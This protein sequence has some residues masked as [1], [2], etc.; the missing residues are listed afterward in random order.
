M[1]VDMYQHPTTTANLKKL[2]S[3][4]NMII[5][6]P[7]GEL[8]SGLQGEGR[9]AEPEDILKVLRELFK[10]KDDL[11]GFSILVTAGPTQERIDQVRFISN[12]S[13]GKMGFA[14]ANALADRGADVNLISGPSSQKIT[15]SRVHEIP[16]ITAIEMYEKCTQ[17]YDQCDVAIFSAAVADFRPAEANEGKIKKSNVDLTLRLKKNPDIAYELGK[18]KK[19]NQINIG[20]A[21]ETDNEIANA[22]LKLNEK[23]FDFIVLNSLKDPGAGF[24]SEKNKITIIDR[25]GKK[26]KFPLKPKAL[27]A[28]DIVDFLVKRLNVS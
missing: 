20:F 4:G 14:L 13:S 1:D 27:V 22:T 24:A 21:L 5:E 23:N 10:K 3:Y 17:L 9:M 18:V 16:V 28:E 25:S 2:S 8:A 19:K 11:K 12:Y 15:N 7:F 26:K 6:A